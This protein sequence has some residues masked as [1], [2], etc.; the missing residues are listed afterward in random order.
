MGRWRGPQQYSSAGGRGC[1]WV[2]TAVSRMAGP[3]ESRSGSMVPAT[4]TGTMGPR[5]AA[6]N[7]KPVQRWVTASA[8]GHQPAIAPAKTQRCVE[9]EQ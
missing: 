7:K 1:T 2:W 3:R 8:K 6:L 5:V 4:K 9:R